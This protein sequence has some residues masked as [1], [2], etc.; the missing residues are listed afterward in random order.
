MTT[1]KKNYTIKLVDS[2]L[3]L[4]QNNKIEVNSSI[5]DI[6]LSSEVHTKS[7]DKLADDNCIEESEESEEYEEYEE[8]STISD[9]EHI[10]EELL[11]KE[12]YYEQDTL[13]YS[14]SEHIYEDLLP[15][16]V[17]AYE[18]VSNENKKNDNISKKHLITG[19]AAI[20]TGPP[21]IDINGRK[22]LITYPF[23]CQIVHTFEDTQLGVKLAFP[24][25]DIH[26]KLPSV[27]IERDFD[28]IDII[29]QEYMNNIQCN[30]LGYQSI[31]DVTSL[32]FQ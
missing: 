10:F 11:P 31:K 8:N 28:E 27:I 23:P 29:E 4:F 17:Y 24:Y 22:A 20:L 9:S 3:E 7:T 13:E 12:V 5:N 32:D 1:I 16:D 19:N 15:V 25:N 26:K 14:V 6:L 30:N 2:L 21:T 18:K